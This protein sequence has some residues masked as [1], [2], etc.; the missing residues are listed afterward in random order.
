MTM[1]YFKI[2]SLTVCLAA[3]LLFMPQRASAQSVSVSFQLFYDEL[4]PHGVWVDYPE[5]GYVWIPNSNP[6]FTPYGTDGHW[7]YT[8]DGWMWVSDYPWGWAAFHYG[9][10]DYDNDMG[11]FWVPDN[12]WGP[13]WVSWRRSP[14]YYGWVPL[15]PG[16]SISIAFG[17]NYYEQNDRWIFVRERDFVRRDVSL[18]IVS[19]TRNS[20]IINKSTVITN[21][22]ND[23]KRNAVYIAGPGRDEVQKTTRVRIDPVNV[24]E[25]ERPG[26]HL[27]KDEIQLY[28]PQIEKRS[29]AGQN[30]APS[31]VVRK[32]EVRPAQTKSAP[33]RRQSAVPADNRKK[34]EPQQKLSP[35]TRKPAEPSSE[36][37]NVREKK[38]QKKPGE[39]IIMERTKRE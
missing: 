34:Q 7:V 8:M 11:W 16:I 21:S 38:P 12:E 23:E 6:G 18:R 2:I 36:K 3:A 17:S 30:P 24:R 5:Y 15:R 39:K 28:R 4:S 35:Q 13:A 14:G 20:A 10:W 32:N 19:R 26:Q 27:R 29:S 9:R 25:N 37:K 1:K 22:R 33:Q 31:K